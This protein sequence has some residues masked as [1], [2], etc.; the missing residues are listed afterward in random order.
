MP[1]STIWDIVSPLTNNSNISYVNES[2]EDAMKKTKVGVSMRTIKE[3]FSSMNSEYEYTPIGFIDSLDE[4]GHTYELVKKSRSILKGNG[5]GFAT[6]MYP[7]IFFFHTKDPSSIMFTSAGYIFVNMSDN[8]EDLDS[9]VYELL[10]EPKTFAFIIAHEVLHN[11]YGHMSETTDIFTL[12]KYLPEIV[13]MV[14]NIYSSNHAAARGAASELRRLQ[15]IAMDAVINESL[16]N[17]TNLLAGQPLRTPDGDIFGIFKETVDETRLNQRISPSSAPLRLPKT[18]KADYDSTWKIFYKL[19]EWMLIHKEEL[20]DEIKKQAAME[21]EKQSKDPAPPQSED[22][23]FLKALKEILRNYPQLDVEDLK[24]ALRK[25]IKEK[26]E[27][28]N[29]K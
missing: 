20:L 24:V 6:V 2:I 21:Q 18:K 23:E 29:K 22:D 1:V 12:Y 13:K 5:L 11:V 10:S 27:S 28:V 7:N 15:N 9:H 16:R 14:Y 25:S 26:L 8:K 17:N 3:I 19:I 4:D